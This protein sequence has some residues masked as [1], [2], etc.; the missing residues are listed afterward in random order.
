MIKSLIGAILPLSILLMG[1]AEPKHSKVEVSPKKSGQQLEWTFKVTPNPN[2]VATFEEAPWSLTL[3]DTKGLKFEGA[4]AD[5]KS[6]Q[7]K[8][9]H[10]KLDQSLPGYKVKATA[11]E[12]TGKMKYEFHTFI[13]TKEKSRCY[14]EVHKGDLN[15]GR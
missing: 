13:C 14:R 5:A 2:M 6:G 11:S 4:T 15:W 3:K 9:A 7:V 1:F 10:D 8:F 12:K